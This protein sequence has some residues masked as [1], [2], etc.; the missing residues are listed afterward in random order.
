MSESFARKCAGKKRHASERRAVEWARKT[1][2]DTGLPM[3]VYICPFCKHW[4]V[5]NAIYANGRTQR[6]E[7]EVA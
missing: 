6:M 2:H 3:K 1:Q 5:G 7:R 4:H